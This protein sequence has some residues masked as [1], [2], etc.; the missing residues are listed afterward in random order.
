[1]TLFTDRRDC[2]GCGACA[3][4]CPAGAVAMRPD[5]EGFSYPSVDAGRCLECGRCAAVCPLAGG[6]ERAPFR[7]APAFYIARN[8]EEEVVRRSASGGAFTA[9]SNQVLRR[10][11]VVYGV[12][13]D[14]ALRA[15]H[16]RAETPAQR[17]RMC[18]SKY[19]QSDLGDAYQRA[20]EDLE[21]G[22]TV[23]FTGT[24]CQLAGLQTYLGR[25]RKNLICCDV[26]CH[27]VSS[28]LMWREY[29]RLLEEENRG[30][31]TSVNF[32]DKREGWQRASTFKGFSYSVDGGPPRDDDRFYRLF[33]GKK[34]IARPACSVCRYARVER[35]TDITIADYWGVEKYAP[36]WAD[37]Y[38]VSFLMVSTPKGEELLNGC[39]GELRFARR[40]PM[41]QVK[42]NHRLR[43]PMGI[44]EE[45]RAA[46]WADYRAEGFAGALRRLGLGG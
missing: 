17:D 37:Y 31:V 6:A 16:A 2:C 15:V 5:E 28:P 3:G 26:I 29:L 44:P 30:R 25:P 1:M 40:D 34:L 32:R 20:G 12:V 46:F 22:R 38:G 9:L 21:A 43:G 19:V 8:R 18:S 41:E 14:G 13:L 42:E 7:P 45:E 10:G 36:E 24:S 33:F 27:S 35:C 23:L 4:V 39:R 11:G